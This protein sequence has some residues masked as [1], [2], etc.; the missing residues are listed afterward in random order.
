MDDRAGMC[1]ERPLYRNAQELLDLATNEAIRLSALVGDALERVPGQRDP[2]RAAHRR[3]H[4]AG[5]DPR[6]RAVSR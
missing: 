1:S 3:R 5:T 2:I 6:R 4:G